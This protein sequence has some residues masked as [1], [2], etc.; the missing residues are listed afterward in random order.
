MTAL[1]D[2]H[3]AK[4][5]LT[6]EF[7]AELDRLIPADDSKPPQGCYFADGKK[8]RCD[9]GVLSAN[10]GGMLTLGRSYLFNPLTKVMADMPTKAEISPGQ[11]G[12]PDP[13][14][15]PCFSR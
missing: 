13:A 5:R 12:N 10:D 11:W 1:T 9:F 8:L 3:R 7:Q 2:R 4:A 6:Q 15:A 14:I